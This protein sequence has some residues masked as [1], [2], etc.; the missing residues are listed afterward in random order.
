[1]ED[2]P[3]NQD[4]EIVQYLRGL[5]ESSKNHTFLDFPTQARDSWRNSVNYESS[6][7]LL[8]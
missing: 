5:T 2:L 3:T 1:M 7:S 8:T 6:F 4:L